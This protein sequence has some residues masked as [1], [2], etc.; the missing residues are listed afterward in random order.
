M[1]K[2]IYSTATQRDQLESAPSTPGADSGDD[3]DSYETDGSGESNSHA[4]RREK[5]KKLSQMDPSAERK[6]K[7]LS[8]LA[9]IRSEFSDNRTKA[10]RPIPVDRE[11]RAFSTC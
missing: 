6:R 9:F 2:V 3:E 11:V 8:I 4:K 10:L 1:F 7:L 5:E